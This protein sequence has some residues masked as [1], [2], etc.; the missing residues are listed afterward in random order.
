MKFW[1]MKFEASYIGF[2]RVEAAPGT[3]LISV[4]KLAE[5][6]TYTRYYHQWFTTSCLY[7]CERVATSASTC[8]FREQICT[9]N[10]RVQNLHFSI[11]INAHKYERI[12][13]TPL[14]HNENKSRKRKISSVKNIPICQAW[15]WNEIRTIIKILILNS[16]RN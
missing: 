12:F 5:T 4:E 8:S 11:F 6:I 14:P 13:T 9:K 10:S 7:L 1:K 3:I 2:Q 16:L 15:M